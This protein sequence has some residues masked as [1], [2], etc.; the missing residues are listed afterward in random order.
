MTFHGGARQGRSRR[1]F[2]TLDAQ[3]NCK[4]ERKGSWLVRSKRSNG[5]RL[6]G[7]ERDGQKDR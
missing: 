6:D 2:D 3:V 5:A 1:V 4:R 7:R